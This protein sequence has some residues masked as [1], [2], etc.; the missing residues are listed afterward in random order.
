MV[1]TNLGRIIAWL[2]V[3]VGSLRAG[4][5]LLFTSM[6]GEA[7]YPRYFGSKTTGEVIDAG[8]MYIMVGVAVGMLAEI[9]RSIAAKPEVT[10]QLE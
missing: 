3:I 5:A 4:S 9:S 8:M 7:M 1:F 2:L 10:K 6:T